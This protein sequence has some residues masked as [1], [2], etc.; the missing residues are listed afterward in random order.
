LT[1]PSIEAAKHVRDLVAFSTDAPVL[2]GQLLEL[3]EEVAKAYDRFLTTVA[4]NDLEL[5][6]RARDVEDAEL[7][8][9]SAVYARDIL[10]Q[11][12]EEVENAPIRFVGRLTRADSDNA[13]FGLRLQERWR[14]RYKLTGKYDKEIEA[15]IEEQNLWN[16]AVVAMV[17]V[18]WVSSAKAQTPEARFFLVDVEPA[19][20]TTD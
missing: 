15:T 3:G 2:Q 1:S 6:W 14:N 8:S 13:Q 16:H 19:D 20:E 12:I 11:P 5:V 9:G 17:Q 7:T 10:A 18:T 4:E